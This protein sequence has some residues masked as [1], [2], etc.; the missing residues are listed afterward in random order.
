MF[1]KDDD[2]NYWNVR[3]VQKFY[4]VEL[5]NNTHVVKGYIPN[6][7]WREEM[8]FFRGKSKKECQEWL[9]EIMTAARFYHG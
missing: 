9:D 8:I 3:Q 2:N 6:A 4:V 7:T 5:C 1:L